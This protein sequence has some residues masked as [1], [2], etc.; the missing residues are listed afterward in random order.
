LLTPNRRGHIEA[1]LYAGDSLDKARA[2]FKDAVRRRPRG[3]HTIRQRA[4]V[5]DQWPK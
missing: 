2:T 1:L 4:R 5:L 3:R